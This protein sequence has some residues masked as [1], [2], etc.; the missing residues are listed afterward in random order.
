[1]ESDPTRKRNTKSTLTH[2]MFLQI[3]NLPYPNYAIH[4]LLLHY[5]IHII[6]YTFFI[7]LFPFKSTPS[8]CIVHFNFSITK[9]NKFNSCTNS[10]NAGRRRSFNYTYQMNALPGLHVCLE[11]QAPTHKLASYYYSTSY[12]Y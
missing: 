3:Q 8:L 1:M 4:L 10:I 7:S 6:F 2:S 9:Q 5:T 11:L 12:Q